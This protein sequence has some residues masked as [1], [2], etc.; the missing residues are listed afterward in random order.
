MSA[1][2]SS[3]HI[4]PDA[5]FWC[6][7]HQ[8]R[9]WVSH[10]HRWKGLASQLLL[11]CEAEQWCMITSKGCCHVSASHVPMGKSAGDV[12]WVVL[13]WGG[14]VGPLSFPAGMPGQ[15]SQT[16]SRTNLEPRGF[17]VRYCIYLYNHLYI[18]NWI[19]IYIMYWYNYYL[20]NIC[21]RYDYIRYHS[22][23]LQK[24][25]ASDCRLRSFEVSLPSAAAYY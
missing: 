18:L 15:T 23:Y 19:I 25:V 4:S 24:N 11:S 9:W 2:Q 12:P 7:G 21:A 17:Y 22:M 20:Y 8:S 16:L 10:P 6:W 3:V 1:W 13:T 5:R 14:P